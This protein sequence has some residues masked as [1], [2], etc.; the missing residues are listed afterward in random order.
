MPSWLDPKDIP[1][2]APLRCTIC[3]RRNIEEGQG[4]GDGT[5]LRFLCQIYS[6]A[7]AETGNKNAFHR[8]LYVFCCPHPICSSAENAHESVVVLRGQL[9]KKND[10]YPSDGEEEDDGSWVQHKSATWEV[11]LCAICGQLASGRCPRA[12]EWFCCKG[13]QK[14]YHR[15]LK[16]G[17]LDLSPYIYTESELVVEEEPQEEKN[18]AGNDTDGKVGDD[19]NQ[20]SIFDD[21]EVDESDELLEQSDLNAMTGIGAG[22]DDPTTLEFYTRIGRADGDVKAQCLRYIRWVDT[23]ENDDDLEQSNGPLWVS[24][25]HQPSKDDIPCCE[26]CGALR[27]F[28]FQI[29]PQMV[30]FVKNDSNGTET[31]KDSIKITEDG[32]RALLAASDIVEKAKADGTVDELPEGF[33]QRQEDLVNK[34]KSTIL[35]DDE[36]EEALDFGT[37][38]VYSCTES[39]DGKDNLES[40]GSYRREF[41][42]RQKPLN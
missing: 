32:K 35:Q 4:G 14:S 7:D 28:E 42:W 10:F 12:N 29:M 13:H 3:Q 5:L 33:Q 41:A 6:P 27:N 19:M 1:T 24:S 39:C 2:N 16:K 34:L 15:A 31:D 20:S 8:S 11:N 17:Q 38:V 18:S 36:D 26:H 25:M 22:T 40:L 21:G 23:E 9:P 30:N 37:I